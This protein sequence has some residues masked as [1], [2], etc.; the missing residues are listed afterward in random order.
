MKK[1]II[2]VLLLLAVIAASGCTNQGTGSGKVINQ[3]R[4]VASFNQI[5]FNGAGELIIT[6]GDKE[7]VTVQADDN[8]MN[9]IKTSVNNNK[10]T[11][12]FDNNMPV[13]TQPVKIYVT[14]K[15]LNSINVTGSGLVKSDNLNVNSLIL[16]INGAGN[17]TL[18]NL[19]AQTLNITLSGAGTIKTSGNVN[20]Q[21]MQISGAGEYNA[22]NLTSKIA[23]VTINGG[24][25]STVKVSDTL[26]AI[27]NGA[28]QISYIGS[29][30][31]T[32]Q[33]SGVGNVNKIG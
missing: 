32:Q 9:N 13:P 4:D 7:S 33:I 14:V 12:S 15:D 30:K 1:Y 5:D 11:I 8:L 16:T 25:K 28:G 19:N 29:P 2:I 22:G 23:T 21:N 24:G 20:E 26:N 27:I 10:L 31:V 3:T 18:N 6:Q 17:S